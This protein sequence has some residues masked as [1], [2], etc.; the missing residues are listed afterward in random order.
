MTGIVRNYIVGIISWGFECGR[1]NKPGYYAPVYPQ[2]EWIRKIIN[3]T[4][5]CKNTDK[6]TK[7]GLAT[8]STTTINIKFILPYLITLFL[9][10]FVSNKLVF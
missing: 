9:I 3:K 8:C 7:N 6:N 5:K 4:N 1:P 2:M 10:Y